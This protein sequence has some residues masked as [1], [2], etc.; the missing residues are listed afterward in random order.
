MT[1]E[2][3]LFLAR[4]GDLLAWPDGQDTEPSKDD[5]PKLLLALQLSES[6]K[7]NIEEMNW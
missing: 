7:K 6:L 1:A 4:R 2:R 3:E 5:A